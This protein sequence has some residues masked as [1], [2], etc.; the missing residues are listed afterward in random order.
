MTWPLTVDA[1]LLDRG[2]TM[3]IGS[4]ELAEP[5]ADEALVAVEWAG[6]CGSD[7]H[8]LRTGAWVVDWPATLGHELYGR[9]VEAPPGSSLHVGTPVVADSRVPCGACDECLR[10]PN[11][12]PNIQFVGEVR[13]GGFASHCVLPVSLLHAVPAHVPGSTAV[14]AEPLAVAIHALSHLHHRPER[15]AILGH[16]PI[17]ALIQIEA[18]RRWPGCTV[19]V[20]EPVAPRRELAR[21]LAASTFES[22]E[23]LTTGG[24]D[25]VIDAAGYRTSLA[26]ALELGDVGAHV[27]LVALAHADATVTPSTLVERRLQISGCHAFVDELPTAVALLA[28]EGSRYA[29]VVTETVDL[30]ELP[31]A[32]A[33]QLRRPDAVKLLV[34]P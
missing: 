1:A 27:L 3:T 18:R 34:R 8:V 11:R 4:R 2:L 20:A 29:P 26:R 24:Y 22:D 30:A 7:L 10:D 32:V 15:I 12:C 5:A 9:I 14:L 25:T 31:D 28:A 13:P 16:G 19:D 6:V 17:G 21:A 23:E 33:R